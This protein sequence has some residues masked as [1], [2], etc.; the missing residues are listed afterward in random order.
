M[1]N[2]KLQP[3][4][5]VFV[6]I[7]EKVPPPIV[8]CISHTNDWHWRGDHLFG[9]SLQGWIEVLA[10]RGYRLV[11][12]H[13]NDALFFN[14]RYLNEP[15]SE[16]TAGS[17]PVRAPASTVLRL[18][19]DGYVPYERSE[20]PYNLNVA[21]WRNG[22]VRARNGRASIHQAKL[23]AALDNMKKTISEYKTYKENNVSFS[24]D[25]NAL[26][27]VDDGKVFLLI[28]KREV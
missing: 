28:P 10:Q 14:V 17:V 2:E 1:E 15:Q 21:H 24:R 8:M 4:L 26:R 6:E 27:R 9:C 11:H 16:F 19:M 5:Y 18:Y 25:I 22:I 13:R 12:V 23:K 7:N 3:P 20:F